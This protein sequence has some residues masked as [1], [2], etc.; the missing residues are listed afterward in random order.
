VWESL[1]EL[2][3][4]SANGCVLRMG[5]RVFTLDGCLPVAESPDTRIACYLGAAVEGG[6]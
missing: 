4:H 2:R 5:S 1:A 3:V 6:C